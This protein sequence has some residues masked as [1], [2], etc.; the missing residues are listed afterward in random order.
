[1]TENR[2][3]IL[4]VR[5]SAIVWGIAFAIASAASGEWIQTTLWVLWTAISTYLLHRV[6]PY[7]VRL[8]P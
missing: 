4:F 6:E 3:F 2:S 8:L 5:W 1:M 7:L